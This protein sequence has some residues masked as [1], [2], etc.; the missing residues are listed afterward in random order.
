VYVGPADYDVVL[1]KPKNM[2]RDR[3]LGETDTANTEIS[4]TRKQSKSSMQNTLLHE[5]LHAIFWTSGFNRQKF[6][7]EQE[8]KVVQAL[9]PWLL[10]VLQDNPDTLAFLLEK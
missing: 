9:T 4:M 5:T 3:L 6:P 1:K 8:E 2:D 10:A 7:M